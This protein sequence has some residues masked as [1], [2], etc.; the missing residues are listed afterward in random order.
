MRSGTFES[1]TRRRLG[2]NHKGRKCLRAAVRATAQAK[3]EANVQGVTAAA[4]LQRAAPVDDGLISAIKLAESKLVAKQ[5]AAS[6]RGPMAAI[7]RLAQ[8][9]GVGGA[10]SWRGRARVEALFGWCR[11]VVFR[12]SSLQKGSAKMYTF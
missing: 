9:L 2:R 5:L 6:C 12:P 3:C 4:V 11:L 10:Q 8:E 1:C 7:A